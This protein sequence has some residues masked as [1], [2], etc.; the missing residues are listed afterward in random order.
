VRKEKEMI[1]RGSIRMFVGLI[2]V[3]GAGGGMDNATDAQLL[4]VLA[5]ALT[6]LAIMYSGVS[7]MK[8]SK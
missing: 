3:M 4:P 1:M 8:G 7:A 6:G 5:I 2:V